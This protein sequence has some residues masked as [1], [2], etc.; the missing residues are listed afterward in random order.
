[1]RQQASRIRD[2]HDDLVVHLGANRV[3]QPVEAFELSRRLR[4]V[5]FIGDREMGPYAV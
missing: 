3:E 4:S 1:M 5:E 2:M